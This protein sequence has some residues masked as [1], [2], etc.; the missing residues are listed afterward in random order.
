MKE[1]FRYAWYQELHAIYKSINGL[2]YYLRKIPFLGKYIPESIFNS[3]EFKTALFWI[4]G[5][6]SIPLRVFGKFFWLAF[7]IFLGNVGINLVNGT[8]NFWYFHKEAYL[9][10]FLFWIC[11]VGISLHGAKALEK[12]IA[13]GERDFVQNFG[14]SWTIYLQKQALVQ[15]FLITIF[16]IPALLTLSF[17]TSSIWFF[18]VGLTSIL[19]WDFAGSALQRTLYIKNIKLPKLLILLFILVS[20]ASVIFLCFFYRHLTAGYLIG[21]LVLQI[22]A[23]ILSYRSIM[24][25]R[26]MEGFTAHF[27]EESANLDKEIFEI[28]QG[29]EYT[30]QGLAMQKKLTLKEGR[31]LSHLS[32]M[33]YLNALLFQRYRSILTRKFIWRM[34]FLLIVLIGGQITMGYS[35][36]ILKDKELL[37]LMPYLFMVMYALSLGRAIAQMVFVNC[38]ISMLHYPFY[39][40][41]K[42]IIA[43]FNYRWFQSFKYSSCFAV[44]LFILL[45]SWGHFSYSPGIIALLALLLLSLTALLSFHDLFIYYVLQPFTKDMEVVNPVYKVLSGGLYWVAYFNFYLDINSVYYV[46]VISGLLILYVIIGYLILLKLAPKT[47]V[48]KR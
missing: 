10:G 29:N 45:L 19:A 42:N 9:L 43:G 2:F 12:T 34:G 35:G 23:L 37:D 20:G 14:L 38:D 26:N 17:M 47:F 21:L 5:I 32:G 22:L 40:Q 7:Y 31:D 33:T 28:T 1:I 8:K 46:F 13:K 16:Y 30:R 11:I 36:V 41:G 6:L 39:R 25:F 27:M 24:N 48:L 18:L 15:P 4:F 3:Y 44:S